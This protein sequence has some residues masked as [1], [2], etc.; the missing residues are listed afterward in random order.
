MKYLIF[1]TFIILCMSEVTNAQTSQKSHEEMELEKQANI[2]KQKA[3]IA[4]AE[5]EA[6]KAKKDAEKLNAP[7][8]EKEQAE[9]D[10][11]IAE[12]N[13]AAIQAKKDQ[14]KGPEVTAPTG[15]ITSDGQFIENKILAQKALKANLSA[16][17]NTMKKD[18]LFSTKATFVI[19]NATDIPAMELYATLTDQLKAMERAYKKANQNAKTI[20]DKE[21]NSTKIDGQVTL[22]VGGIQLAGY[23][24]SG[25]IKTAADLVS[26]FKTTTDYKNFDIVIDEAGLVASLNE[27]AKAESANWKF[28]QPSVFPINTV[29]NKS[30]ASP[31]IN[32][33]N[34]VQKE[35]NVAE[36]NIK[37]LEKIIETKTK[38]LSTEKDPAKKASIQKY[39]DEITPIANELKTFN[40]SLS[41]LQTLLST[42]DSSTKITAQ[43]AIMRAERL[44]TKL[45]EE[46]T[47]V[48]NISAS[49]KGSNKVSENL[50]RNAR[51]E[52]SGG[53]ELKCL[54][55]GP[56][57]EIVFS[58]S[59]FEYVP[60]QSPSQIREK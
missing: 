38:V 60:Y 30:S 39:I 49:A 11:A 18:K 40:N 37:S 44:I 34:D 46:N 57:G 24:A 15:K 59:H 54:I 20:I 36:N 29:T 21:N 12:A 14:F 48:M 25:L 19:Y 52:H 28:F 51:I 55:Y 35:K 50:W 8:S 58:F 43:A 10:K 26:L 47:Y 3:E 33:M 31:F 32:S 17:V 6:A 5:L 53:A 22:D 23:A 56:D 2:A 27:T 13:K 41:Q 16:M 9:T 42:A 4:K 45:R 7:P 1:L